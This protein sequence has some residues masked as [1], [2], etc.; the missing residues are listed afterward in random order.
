MG[1]IKGMTVMLHEKAQTGVDAFNRPIY[2]EM[3]TPVDNVLVG[4]PT[5]EDVTN[6]LNLSGKRIAYVLALPKGDTHEWHDREV[7][8]WGQRFK[9]IGFPTQGIEENIPLSWNKKVK[10]ERHG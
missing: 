7:S 2:E 4:E 10:V 3:D 8:F 6:E 5:A 9:V 1:G